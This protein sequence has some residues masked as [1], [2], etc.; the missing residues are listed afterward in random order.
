MPSA[1]APLRVLQS[2]VITS[3]SALLLIALFSR[4]LRAS[5]KESKSRRKRFK[6]VEDV[7]VVVGSADKKDTATYDFVIVGGG[8]QTPSA[9]FSFARDN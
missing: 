5:G 1:A 6:S 8:E 9:S 2:I 3:A 7:G 4:F